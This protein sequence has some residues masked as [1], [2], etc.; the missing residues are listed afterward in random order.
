MGGMME[1][2]LRRIG[3]NRAFRARHGMPG[4]AGRE[5]SEL[6]FKSF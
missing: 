5:I 2:G 6:I 1:T 3:R 4:R